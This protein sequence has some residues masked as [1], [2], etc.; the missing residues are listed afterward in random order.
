MNRARPVEI[1]GGGL[2]GLSLGLALRRRGVPVVLHERGAYPRHRVC[3]EFIRGL[4]PATIVE[5]E[6]APVLAAARPHRHI[7]WFWRDENLRTQRLSAPAFAISRHTLDA[8]L[9][10]NFQRAGGELHTASRIDPLAAEGRV[11][12]HGRPTDPRSPWLGLKLHVRGLPLACGLEMHLGE[13]AYVGL[14]ELPDGAVNICGLFRRRELT[15]P[16]PELLG[17]YLEAAGLTTLATRLA[18]ATPVEGSHAAMAGLLFGRHA[19]IAPSLGDALGMIPPF[20]GNGM[21]IAFE[22]ARLAADPLAAWAHGEGNWPAALGELQRRLARRFRTRLSAATACHPF[23]LR[24]E[25]QRWV[26]RA[27]RH[28]ALPLAALTRL[29]S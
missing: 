4:P 5:L 20:T 9:A 1:I 13:H 8:T 7:A 16:A 12:A 2:A 19:S 6:L 10:E 17:A 11:L 29:L 28:H 21:A 26:A 27:A 14:C 25:P 24:P 18:A 22:S 3:G 15:R 23:L